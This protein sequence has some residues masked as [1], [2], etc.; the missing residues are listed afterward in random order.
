M[1][2]LGGASVVVT[3]GGRFIWA[4]FLSDSSAGIAVR[5]ADLAQLPVTAVSEQSCIS[6]GLLNTSAAPA[7]S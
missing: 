2:M 5:S 1:A 6:L 7:I 4:D 3:V